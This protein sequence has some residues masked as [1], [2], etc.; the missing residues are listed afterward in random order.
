MKYDK[1]TAKVVEFDFAEFMAGSLVNGTCSGYTDSVGHVCGSYVQGSSCS[2]WTSPSFG[3][4]ICDN[5]DGH[6]CRSYTDDKHP[7]SN[8]CREYGTTCR[9]F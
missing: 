1:P 6:I 2:A 9:V 5:Y 8:P 3:G 4:A 7:A